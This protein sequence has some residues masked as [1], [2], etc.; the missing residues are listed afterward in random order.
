[1]V[2]GGVLGA[3]IPAAEAQWHNLAPR[4]DAYADAL[5]ERRVDAC[6][7]HRGGLRSDLLYDREVACLDQR[8][9]GFVRLA[10]LLAA[11]DAEVVLEAPRAIAALPTI[12][13]CSDAEALSA[14]WLR[15]E[16]PAVR[17]RAL[18]LR[19]ELA[20]AQ[21]EEAAGKY[22]EAEARAAEVLREA[23]GI[24]D[25]PLRAEAALRWGSAG[26]QR[27]AA[28]ASARLDMSL[29]TASDGAAAGRCRGGGPPDLRPGGDRR[30][31]GGERRGDRPRRRPSSIAG[32]PPT[33]GSAGSSPTTRRSPASRPGRCARRWR[34]TATRSR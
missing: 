13:A 31:P 32:A 21:A 29:W 20:R 3:A 25:L 28:D 30:G 11:G 18:A 9:A 24:D 12:A 22:A 1:M 10:E 17:E 14:E 23:K 7:R 8:E 33:G 16:E 34:P 4:L 2:E 6:E 5:V 19:Q 15:P 26:V 27:S